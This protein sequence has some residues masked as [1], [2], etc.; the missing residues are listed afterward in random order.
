MRAVQIEVYTL[1]ELTPEARAVA[2][3]NY[4][5]SLDYDQLLADDMQ[6]LLEDTLEGAGATELYVKPRY[7]LSYS[8]GDGASFTGSFKHADKWVVVVEPN[9]FGVHYSHWNSVGVAQCYDSDT[10]TEA[11][12]EV[13][14]EVRELV[15]STGRELERRGYDMLETAYSD[16]SIAEALD[17]CEFTADG[18]RYYGHE[19]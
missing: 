8:Q 2:F 7:S 5:D 16:E 14:K 3:A 12:A 19:D 18:A 4:S 9:Q 13:L 1:D 10:E 11:P 17:G 6:Y 15:A